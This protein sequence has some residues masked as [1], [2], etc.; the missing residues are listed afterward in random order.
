MKKPSATPKNVI[1]F[2]A[3]I[4]AFL[5]GILFE[6]LITPH[7]QPEI[8]PVVTAAANEK[9]WKA[10]KNVDD[11]LIANCSENF[12]TVSSIFDAQARG[13]TETVNKMNE[14]LQLGADTAQRLA[15]ERA[16]SIRRLAL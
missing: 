2:W 5:V 1:I 4:G 15:E 9:D 7:A 8:K 12:S 14:N 11:R 13:D 6:S 10:L 3:I 16:E